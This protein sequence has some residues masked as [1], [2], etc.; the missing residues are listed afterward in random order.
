MRNNLVAF[1]IATGEFAPE[2]WSSCEHGYP[3]QIHFVE[4]LAAVLS[5]CM[6]YSTG[7]KSV[8]TLTPL[9]GDARLSIEFEPLGEEEYTTGNGLVLGPDGRAYLVDSDAGAIVEIDVEGMRVLRT[10]YYKEAMEPGSWLQRLHAWLLELAASP[11]RAKRWLAEPAISPDG[12]SLAVDGGFSEQGGSSRSVWLVDLESLQASQE[13]E[14]SGS[15]HTIRFASNELLYI[16]LQNEGSS[17]SNDLVVYDLAGDQAY[18]FSFET[19][20]WLSELMVLQ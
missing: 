18:N 6:D 4:E 14:L 3:A 19:R 20:G 8:V 13:I 17:T 1:D 2:A 16:L 9:N 11:A 15:P 12:R 7:L 5:L 10:A